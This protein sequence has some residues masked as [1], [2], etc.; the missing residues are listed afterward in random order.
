MGGP[1]KA[2][3]GSIWPVVLFA[4]VVLGAGLGVMAVKVSAL[5]AGAV[6]A[7][8]TAVLGVVGTHAGHM[9]GHQLADRPRTGS[10]ADGLQ[11]L[12][13]LHAIKALDDAEFAAAK[14]ALISQHQ[15]KALKKPD[16]RGAETDEAE[17]AAQD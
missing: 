8:A 4:L 6:T 3:T 16:R 17:T 12:T 10:I 2:V 7:L 1:P 5:T 14:Q 15:D 13:Q 11:R 9:A